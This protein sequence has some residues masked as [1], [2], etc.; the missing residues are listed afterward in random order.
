M[1]TMGCLLAIDVPAIHNGY[2]FTRV[3]VTA[4]CIV[5][6]FEVIATAVLETNTTGYGHHF[7][8]A[9]RIGCVY[10]DSVCL[11]QIP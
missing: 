4:R 5:S 2:L 9:R 11:M 8:K 10:T 7:L 1:R 6:G 3:D